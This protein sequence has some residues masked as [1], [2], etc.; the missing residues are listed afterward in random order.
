MVV[1]IGWLPGPRQSRPRRAARTP[2]TQLPG[3]T[4][5]AAGW[6]SLF[7][8][9][10][11]YIEQKNLW[12]SNRVPYYNGAYYDWGNGTNGSYNI[13]AT[14]VKTY[15]NPSD[16]TATGNGI[17]PNFT[18]G[19]FTGAAFGGFAV[20]VLENL[21]GA[22]VVGSEAKL[23]VALAII[24]GVLVLRPSGLFGSKEIGRV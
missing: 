18:V 24:V 7:F 6:G 20:G 12:V 21:M 2:F 16:P 5:G 4:G 19:N 22:Y 17:D 10:L 9:L 14:P 11:P 8:E 3:R 1:L 13:M 15:Q 23:S